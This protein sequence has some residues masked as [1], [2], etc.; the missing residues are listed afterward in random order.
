M[1]DSIRFNIDEWQVAAQERKRNRMKVIIKLNKQETEAFR[2]F[3]ETVKPAELSDDQFLK[4]I[5][6]YGIDAINT[7]LAEAVKQYAEEHKDELAT[8]GIEVST[9]G[10]V[11]Q[12]HSIESEG[13]VE[14]IDSS[15][16]E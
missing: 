15:E 6:M 4:S 9:S 5:F 7:E 11:A 3:T 8:S 14:M 13:S 16:E 10:P 1:P 12:F 2:S